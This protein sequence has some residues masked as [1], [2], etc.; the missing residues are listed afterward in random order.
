MEQEHRITLGIVF[1]ENKVFFL[2]NILAEGKL[3]LW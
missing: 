2:Q 3:Q 1:F